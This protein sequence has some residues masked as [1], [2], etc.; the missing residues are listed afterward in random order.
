M[1]FIS[2]CSTS[3]KRYRSLAASG[4][5]STLADVDLF[6]SRLETSNPAVNGKTL[7]DLTADAQ[8]QFIKIMNTRYP[9][10]GKFL[11]SL[12]YEFLKGDNE[13]ESS[14]YVR[15]DL[16]LVISVSRKRNYNGSNSSGEPVLCPAD[17]IEYLRI[18]LVLDE[19]SLQF[20]GWNMYTTEY[21]SIDIGDVSFTKSLG[22]DISTTLPVKV[23]DYRGTVTPGA[24][25][26]VSRKE[27][28]QV[29][30]RYIKLNGRLNDTMLVMEEEGT[31]ETD[32]T[33][34]ILADVSLKF[35]SSQE[36]ITRI[37]NL[38]D[39]TGNY[40]PPSKLLVEGFLSDVPDMNIIRK[41]IGAKLITDFVYRNVKGGR[42]TFPEWDDRVKYYT[43]HREKHVVLFRDADY[44]PGLFGIGSGQGGS[45]KEFITMENR[46]GRNTRLIFGSYGE[47]AA[48]CSWLK[49]WLGTNE[50]KTVKIGGNLLTFKY[51]A[52][53]K[54]VMDSDPRFGVI[55]YY[56]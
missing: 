24:T 55:P 50:E 32:L 25:A 51:E 20:T 41:E 47:A 39:S 46:E 42:K 12:R 29:R 7:L 56:W 15:K 3:L 30:Y 34:N 35:S 28:Q 37:K 11:S 27:D 6:G 38:N 53:T 33:G 13:S 31:R 54:K 49:D 48:F 8:S 52:L 40:N 2:S 5:D 9:D 1:V 26:S 14:D 43:G 19:P 10:N 36:Y 22:T 18:S 4:T 23:N 17:R 16:R 45:R 44:V 21:G